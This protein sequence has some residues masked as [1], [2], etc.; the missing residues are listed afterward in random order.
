MS[1]KKIV[2]KRNKGD[3]PVED[4][5]LEEIE[6][7]CKEYL[8]G[9]QRA[10][11]DYSNLQKESVRE[12]EQFT[13]FAKIQWIIQVIPLYSNLQTAFIHLPKSLEDDQWALGI[14][15][16]KDQFAAVLKE[17]KVEQISVSGD[18]DASVHEAVSKEKKD[19]V[20]PGNILREVEP[21][22]K[23]D[24]EV[25]VPAKVVVAE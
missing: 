15:H 4:V 5:K 24:N 17:L 8:D 18:F 21:G 2:K 25:I 14:R 16:I 23:I 13:K 22:Y 20:K 9:W 1:N 19:N 6:N 11:A 7:K 10:K 3:K 12:R